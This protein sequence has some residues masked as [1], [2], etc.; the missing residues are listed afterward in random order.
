MSD[1]AQNLPSSPGVPEEDEINLLDLFIVLLKHKVMIISVVFLAGIAALVMSLQMPNVYRS[2][3]TIAPTTQEKSGG[4]LAALGGFG[5]MI[6]AEVGIGGSGSLDQFDVVLK[7]RELT[8]AVI[9]DRNLLPVIYKKSWDAKKGDWKAADPPSLLQ[10]VSAAILGMVKTTPEKKK[11]T[12]RSPSLQDAYTAIQ[13]MIS[14]KPDKKQNVMRISC[15]SEDPEMAK[16]IVNYYIVG[17]S[18]FLRLQM[19]EEAAAQ[20]VDLS[21]QLA[22]TSD[23]LLKI[24]LYELIARQMEKETL[25]RV[26]KYFGFNVVDPP[27][28]PEQKFKPKRAQICMI[29]VVVAFFIAVFLAFFMEYVKNLRTRED[30]E[31]LANLRNAF[32][33]RTR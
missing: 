29:S 17:M 1:D 7:S 27:Y 12:S 5:A 11:E 4:G 24:R 20:Q 13:G 25:A 22:R 16:D 14:L 8:N 18:D 23:P 33:L 3:A 6:A 26:Q 31:R 15:E 9:R 21:K 10:Q 28:V 30:P 32:R 19:L 2:E